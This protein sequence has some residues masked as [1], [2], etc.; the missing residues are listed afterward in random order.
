MT[1]WLKSKR[2]ERRERL[3]QGVEPP[4]G[5]G[6]EATGGLRAAAAPHALTRRLL[7]VIAGSALVAGCAV[8]GSGI[9]RLSEGVGYYWQTITGHLS[10]LQRAEPVGSL[11]A[12][13]DLDDRTRQRLE[14][15][16]RIRRFAV[17]DLGLP[18][19]GSYTRFA[20]IKQPF[21]TWGVVAAPEL[22][23][24]LT[25]WCFPVAGCVTYRGYYSLEAAEAYAAGL[26]AQG[27]DVQINGVP[28]YSTLGWLDD[29]LLSTFIN[30]PDAEVARLIFHEL[31]HQV[32]YVPGDSMFNESFASTVEQLGVERWLGL[33]GTPE[34]RLAYRQQRLRRDG[35]LELLGRHRDK[36]AAVYAARIPDDEK[37]EGKRRAFEALK[38]E[39]QQMRQGPWAGFAGYDR[40]FSRPLGNAHLG[41]IATYTTWVPVFRQL[42]DESGEDFARFYLKVGELAALDRAERQAFLVRRSDRLLDQD[43]LTPPG[44]EP[45][46]RSLDEARDG[47]ARQLPARDQVVHLRDEAA[48]PAISGQIQAREHATG[49]TIRAYR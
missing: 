11:L 2:S 10:I 39:Y 14:L 19:N 28:A 15:A 16:S 4:P 1:A 27:L 48:Q 3:P 37:R 46:A 47:G 26:A 43:V 9:S 45:P 32:V 5:S 30:Y 34:Q 42:F 29:P 25:Q 20:D 6:A 40:W 21:V 7:T 33:H 31:S 13:A 44:A 18:D 35:F 38:A 49:A 41:S 24:R 22:S 12:Q 23:L 17:T 36:L 8:F